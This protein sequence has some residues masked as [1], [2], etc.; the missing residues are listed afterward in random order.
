MDKLKRVVW[1]DG[2]K[3]KLAR[4]V[5]SLQMADPNLT[6]WQAFKKAEPLVLHPSRVRNVLAYSVVESWLPTYMTR[7]RLLENPNSNIMGYS[8]PPVYQSTSQPI[9][10]VQVQEVPKQEV[11]NIVYEVQEQVEEATAPVQ[12]PTPAA[13]LHEVLALAIEQAIKQSTISKPVESGSKSVVVDLS[14]TNNSINA[15]LGAVG[16]LRLEIFR[17]TDE[18]QM[19]KN[20]STQLKEGISQLKVHINAE[21][22]K[23]TSA[24]INHFKND[25]I[26]EV[27][28][29]IE[30]IKKRKK[31]ILL[32]GISPKQYQDLLP[33]YESKFDLR[34]W[35]AD[36]STDKLKS[37]AANA[38]I[39]LGMVD[40]IGHTATEIITSINKVAWQP[41]CGG[42]TTLK[43][44]LDN[45][46]EE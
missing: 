37:K 21:V 3:L 46:K 35:G 27:P 41:F 43:S 5:I 44:K 23:S 29:P 42:L 18:I 13:P 2:E 6:T 31:Y 38:H 28:A 1:D 45:I 36:E 20:E 22:T 15:L 14:E 16:E 9:P 40:L 24:I 7:A 4:K 33:L 19:L 39:I 11:R 32:V 10:Q 26:E 34:M 17:L 25:V 8:K 30:Q 12:A